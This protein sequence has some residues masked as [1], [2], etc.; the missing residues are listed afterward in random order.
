MLKIVTKKSEWKKVFNTL[1]EKSILCSFEYLNAAEELEV[2]GRAQL[3]TFQEGENLVVHPYILRKIKGTKFFDI[4]SVYDFGGFWF[5]CSSSNDKINL[6]KKFDK[7]FT[8]Y[9]NEKKIITEFIRLYPFFDHNLLKQTSYIL[10]HQKDNVIIKFSDYEFADIYNNFSP[11]RKNQV[12]QAKNKNNLSI[13][14]EKEINKFIEIY[15]NNLDRL[16]ASQFFYFS[17][18]FFE[19]TID[20]YDIFYIYDYDKNLCAGHIYLKDYDKYFVYLTAGVQEKFNLRP[21]CFA[22]YN[23]IKYAL[24]N[25]FKHFHFGGGGDSLYRYKK[26]FSKE[27]IPYFTCKKV[28]DMDTYN[29][30]VNKSK[31][32]LTTQF[33]DNFFPEY[34]RFEITFKP[35]EMVELN[36]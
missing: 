31:G 19:K 4:V 30:L 23:S 27:T 22:Y 20:F 10:E 25:K 11:K 26:S 3:A 21:N 1:L 14:K 32:N 29:I 13:I 18:S 12:M 36:E 9:C 6:L 33:L 7:Y 15:Y 8:L 17:K 2:S 28:Y 34:R 24:K 35:K 5:N 16:S